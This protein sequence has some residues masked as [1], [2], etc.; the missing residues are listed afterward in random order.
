MNATPQY[1]SGVGRLFPSLERWQ[2]ERGT[3][4]ADRGGRTRRRFPIR[5]LF[6]SLAVCALLG[7][8]AAEAGSLAPGPRVVAEYDR[9]FIERTGAQTLEELLDTG[10]IRYFLT[11]GQALLVLVD[12]RPYSTTGGDLDPLPLSAVERIEILGGDSLGTLGAGTLRGALNVVLRKDLDGFETRVLSRMPSRDGGDG[13]QGSV[14]WGGAVGQGRLTLG[15][16]ISNRQEI[17][18]RSREHS[19]SDWAGVETF[20]QAKNVSVSGNTVFV[21]KLDEDGSR[22]LDEN[23]MPLP[24]R[25][26]ALGDCDPVHGYVPGLSNPPGIT[27][28]DLGCG[29]AYGNIWWDTSSREQQTA[30]LVLDHPLGDDAELHLDANFTQYETGFQ[31]AP[32]VDVFSFDPTD[33]LLTAINEAAGSAFEADANDWFS[34]GHRLVGHGNRF[35]TTEGEEYDI[36]LGVEG[37]LTEGMG[38]DARF[39]AYRWDS[40]LT[41]DNL[42]RATTIREKIKAGE[43]DLVNPFSDDPVHL[44]AI[45]DSRVTE[46]EDSGSQSLSA[47]LALEG[48]GFSIGNRD[49]AWTTGIE[50]GTVES[51]QLLRF[52]DRHDA[53]HPVTDV[54]GS[55]GVSYAGERTY[56]AAFGEALLPVADRLDFRVAG[57]GSELD[58][59]GG[60]GSW[61]LGAEYRA[62]DIVTL[63][64]SWSTGESSPSMAHLYSTEVQGHPYVLCDP[65]SGPPPRT[66]P[67]PNPR[68]VTQELSG[69]LDLDPVKGERLAFGAEA[70]QGPFFV[71]GEWYRQST[72]D[73]VGLNTATWAILNLHECEP[74]GA[75]VNCIEREGGGDITLHRGFE[76]IA[77]SQI[78]GVNTRFGAG[79]RTSWGVVGMRGAWRY[80]VDAERR[81]AGVESRYVIARN[82]FRVGFLVKRGNVSAIWTANYRS[83]FENQ[84]ETG[85]FESWTGHD[86]VVDWADPLGFEGARFSAGV[87]NLTDTPLTTDTA[88]PNSTDGPTAAG[89]GRTFFLTFNMTF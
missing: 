39:D 45:K 12:G 25:S 59:V 20:S 46:E 50:L 82:A 56:V 89:W 17:P 58:D 27:T 86:V 9:N 65:G 54:L 26:V 21:V 3:E 30:I 61:R 29:F 87:F 53:T 42:V 68:Q 5:T 43:Y 24:T 49:A 60:L 11:G 33:D 6:A 47:R 14:F 34:V 55:G 88:N 10:I 70:R 84:T 4:V 62:T 74:D 79:F 8:S 28:G 75:K 67:A 19:R 77:E 37:R 57:R 73:G 63:R 48:S 76:N 41:G 23:G 7:V 35:W 2:A 13:R 80:V 16:D 78:S 71:G 64:G 1:P 38:Y 32:S 72:S 36:S 18:G 22:Q 51:H 15:A 44:E 40:F 52:R 83:G 31:Y 66:C 81:Y 85:E 69:N